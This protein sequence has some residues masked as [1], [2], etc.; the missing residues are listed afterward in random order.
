MALPADSIT[1]IPS[2]LA[3][4][5]ARKKALK[6]KSL[7]PNCEAPA[8]CA[9]FG[10]GDG[11]VGIAVVAVV[12][13]VDV[14][15]AAV[16]VAIGDP[17]DMAIR[18]VVVDSCTGGGTGT[19]VAPR[20]IP[21]RTVGDASQ[22]VAAARDLR[23]REDREYSAMVGMEAEVRAAA[24]INWVGGEDGAGVGLLPGLIGWKATRTLFAATIVARNSTEAEAQGRSRSRMSRAL[25]WGLSTRIGTSI[26]ARIRSSI[27]LDLAAGAPKTTGR[28]RRQFGKQL[29]MEMAM[30]MEMELRLWPRL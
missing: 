27:G 25:R 13:V 15:A 28:M 7:H 30:E 22:R 12:D 2:S 4:R 23:L 9:S 11:D 6:P 18:P 19:A 17:R 29:E 14:V 26:G 10:D 1:A 8:N 3:R 5:S 24:A 16:V 20:T 21:N